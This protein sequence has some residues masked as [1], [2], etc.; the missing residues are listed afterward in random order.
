M[1]APLCTA[2]RLADDGVLVATIGVGEIREPAVAYDLRNEMLALVEEAGTQHLIIDARNLA[3]IGSVGFLSFLGV[4]REI[5]GRIVLCNLAQT[6]Y[7]SFAVC[8]LIP[9][10][11]DGIAPFEVARTLEEAIARFIRAP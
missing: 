1:N 7:Q 3:S 2:T 9:L 11:D 5:K 10:N 8:R 6:I 4:R